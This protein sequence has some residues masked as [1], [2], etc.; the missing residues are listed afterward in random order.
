MLILGM[1]TSS[2]TLSIALEKGGRII[3]E[4]SRNLAKRH[5]SMLV[6]MID[7]A[8]DLLRLKF[9]DIDGFIIG[10]GPG[11]FTGLRVGVATVKGFGLA[12][13]KPCIGI[14]SIDA[15]A[16]FVCKR[17]KDADTRG[18]HADGRGLSSEISANIRVPNRVYPRLKWIVPIIDAKRSQVYSALYRY[19]DGN[20]KRYSDYLLLPI[21]RLL[22][23][24]KGDAV[25]LGDGLKTFKEKLSSLKKESEFLP[26]DFWYPKASEL[27]RLGRD[28]VKRYKESDLNKLLPMYIYP[29]EC[30]VK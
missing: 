8:L 22:K 24:I 10:I 19:R 20:I 6:P 12:T 28:K 9:N 3:Y 11:S 26:E 29:K 14:P 23:K 27:I 4:D 25:F 30:Q 2:N 7:S 13:K 17:Y 1:D 16:S 5:S 15:I 21:E 18:L